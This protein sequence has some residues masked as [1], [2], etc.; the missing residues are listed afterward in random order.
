MPARHWYL[1]AA[2]AVPKAR[3]ITI[4]IP[5]PAAAPNRITLDGPTRLQIAA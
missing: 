5:C 2:A 4:T 1:A 3:G